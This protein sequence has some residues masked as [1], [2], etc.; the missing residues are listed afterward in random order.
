MAAGASGPAPGFWE[1][2]QGAE[3][4]IPDWTTILCNTL[5]LTAAGAVVLGTVALAWA[6]A[7]Y[8]LLWQVPLFR[9][10]IGAKPIGKGYASDQERQRRPRTLQY[11]RAEPQ[12]AAGRKDDL[13]LDAAVARE[14]SLPAAQLDRVI[15]ELTTCRRL[16][17]SAAH[18]SVASVLARHHDLLLLEVTPAIGAALDLPTAQKLID[19]LLLHHALDVPVLLLQ[20][21]TRVIKAPG[22]ASHAQQKRCIRRL[23]STAIQERDLEAELL[24]SPLAA[25]LHEFDRVLVNF[26][27]NY[28]NYMRGSSYWTATA[29]RL[30][31]HGLTAALLA[32]ILAQLPHNLSAWPPLLTKL[33]NLHARKLLQALFNTIKTLL[34]LRSLRKHSRPPVSLALAEQLAVKVFQSNDSPPTG[35]AEAPFHL[36]FDLNAEDP[37]VQAVR[38]L[39]AGPLPP[40]DDE[41]LAPTSSEATAPRTGAVAGSEDAASP[42]PASGSP[43]VQPTEEAWDSDDEFEPLP[44]YAQPMPTGPRYLRDALEVLGE[45]DVAFERWLEG[46]KSLAELTAQQPADLAELA[47]PLLRRL[48][49]LENSFN[50]QTFDGLKQTIMVNIVVAQPTLSA[51]FL[52]TTFFEEEMALQHRDLL[53]TVINGAAQRLSGR[54]LLDDQHTPPAAPST[55]ST[56][57]SVDPS[58]KPPDQPAT[59]EA[60]IQARLAQKTRRFHSRARATEWGRANAFAEIGPQL[61]Y[62]LV[63]YHDRRVRTMRLMEDDTWLLANLIRTL[64]TII[65]CMGPALANAHAISTYIEWVC[66]AE[67]CAG[68]LMALRVAGEGLIVE[69]FVLAMGTL[70]S[71]L[72]K[73]MVSTDFAPLQRLSAMTRAA[74]G[75]Y[76]PKLLSNVA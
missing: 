74:L 24:H 4:T 37:L 15:D 46:L 13:S 69:D 61:F 71:W 66:F 18:D 28:A 73:I 40:V 20:A 67:T 25:Q 60:I 6:L 41:R 14:H 12:G 49:R 29:T 30:L 31:D 56:A 72:E 48:L 50:E 21:L 39:A 42:A 43:S 8:L 53:L 16:L 34:A 23:L 1:W 17:L 76:R 32:G 36:D 58:S 3:W 7:Y 44:A 19:D 68:L 11:Q 55:T 5:R 47:V 45:K 62:P 9:E 75:A 57:T 35:D 70:D 65:Y 26:P 27:V 33:T 22:S 52:T 59:P 2:V 64:S 63:A 10:L 38:E 51:P 54:S